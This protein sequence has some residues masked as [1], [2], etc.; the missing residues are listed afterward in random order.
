MTEGICGEVAQAIQAG[1][2]HGAALVLGTNGKIDRFTESHLG[3]QK[4]LAEEGTD[5]SNAGE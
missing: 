4:K 3:L 2:L 1:N 5:P